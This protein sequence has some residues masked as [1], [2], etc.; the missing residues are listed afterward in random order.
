LLSAQG[1]ISTSKQSNKTLSAMVKERDAKGMDPLT[2][3]VSFKLVHMF[4]GTLVLY[5][6]IL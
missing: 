6:P 3:K 1:F 2:L 4:F 5:T